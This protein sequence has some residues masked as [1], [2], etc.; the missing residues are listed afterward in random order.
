MGTEEDVNK[1]LSQ[2]RFGNEMAVR[3][4]FQGADMGGAGGRRDGPVSFEKQNLELDPFGHD[5]F[6]NQAKKGK[7]GLDRSSVG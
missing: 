4:G 1:L 2:D 3:R 7:R 5:E 6:L